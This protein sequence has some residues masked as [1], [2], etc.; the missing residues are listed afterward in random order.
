M[1]AVQG[2]AILLDRWF[3]IVVI[4]LLRCL[5]IRRMWLWTMLVMFSHWN[6]VALRVLARVRYLHVI[7]L[8]FGSIIV[9]ARIAFVL[10]TRFFF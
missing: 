1:C 6:A 5:L 4:G 7:A 10:L 2:V 8:R 9:P 3:E